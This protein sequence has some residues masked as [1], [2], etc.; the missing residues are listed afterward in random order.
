MLLSPRHI[1]TSALAALLVAAFLVFFG[2]SSLA[3][4]RP[5]NSGESNSPPVAVDDSYTTHGH[6]LLTPIEN[7]SDPDNDVINI[8]T[9]TQPQHGALE[10]YSSTVLHYWPASGYV[11]SDC[12]TYTIRDSSGNF[13]SA[14]INITIVNQAPV[15]V[16]D[17]YTVHGQLMISPKD[18]DYD[19]EGDGV[20]FQAIG[21]QPQHGTLTAYNYTGGYTYH[22]TYGYVGSDSFTYTI[23][24]GLGLTAT[25]TVNI[26][27]VNEGPVA[28]DDSYA[29][30]GQRV[31]ALRDNDYDPEG[32]GV[33]FQ[34]I[35]TQPQHGTLAVV[36]YTGTFTYMAAYGYIGPDS[37]TY[38]IQDGLGAT[39][40]G[41]V[42]IDVINQS[43]VPI[44]DVF[45]WRW[46]LTMYPTQNDFDPD[47]GDGI[48]IRD[49]WLN[50]QFGS[51]NGYPG[52][53]YTYVPSSN[54][55]G[56]DIFGYTLVDSYG[57]VA[58]G[59]ALIFAP[60]DSIN[61]GK[62][63][64]KGVGAP[65]DVTN[66]NMYLSQSDY[67]LPGAG[68]GLGV[69]RSYNSK[70]QAI[71]LFGR[72]WSTDYDNNIVADNSYLVHFR[73]GD[74]RVIYFFRP[75]ST[76]AFTP[77]L[78]DFHGQVTQGANG[79]T[80]SFQ[81]GSVQQFDA[82]GKLISLTDSNGNTTS[83]TYGAGGF[84][85]TVT[86]PVGRSL[87]VTTNGNGRATSIADTTGTIATYTYGGGNELLS[88]TYADNSGFHF[89]YDG[90][91]RLLTVTDALNNIVESHAYDSQGRATTSERQGGVEHY[92]L[93]YVSSTET[94]VT[95]ALSHVTKYTFDT[96]KG[97]NLLTRVEGVCGCGGGGGSQVQTW[98]YD[99]KLNL[100]SKTD[101]L[102]HITSFTYDANGNRLT[103]TDATGTVTYTYNGFGE[104]LT[105]TDQLNGVAMMTYD[106]HA[107]L[108]TLK[109]PLNNTTTFT[110][111]TRGQLLTSTDA[112]GKVTTFS[113]DTN[114]N[115]SENE[116]ANGNVTSFTHDD[117]GRLT[118]VHDALSHVTQYGY[119]VAG[120]LNRIT[121][122]DLS[123]AA[124][125]YDL[126]GRRTVITDERGNSTN[127]AYD[128]A[129]RLTSVTDAANHATTYGYDAMSK[130]TSVTDALSRVTNYD[131][132][133][134][135]RLIK[136][137]YP[138]ATTG[139]TRLFESIAYDA[140]GNVT[141][142]TDT[143]G[144]VTSYAYDNANR[145]ISTT[146]PA[147]KTTSYQYDALS[148]VTS[149][150]DALN[151]QYQ[152]GYDA[153]S[154]Q[155]Q[156]T[157]GGVSMTYVYDAVGNRSQRTDYNGVVTNYAYDDLNRLTTITYPD[158]TTVNYT[159]DEISRLAT[160]TN[161]NGTVTVGYDNR[162]RTANV[163]GPFGQTVSYG[164]DVDGNR[165]SL[166]IGGSTYA[167]YAYD[168]LNRLSSI[169]DS[170]SLAVNYSYDVTN[171]LTS[172]ILP[173]GV[174][175]SYEYDGLNRLTRLRNTTTSATLTD[176]QYT[177]DTANRISQLTDLGGTHAYGYDS[178][179]RVTTATYP[180][181]A[182]ESYTYDGV[183]NRTASH[184]SASYTYQPFNR[185]TSAGGATYTYDNNGNLLSKVSA[186]D[187]TQYAWDYENR[188]TQVTLPN[189]TVVNY[190]YDALGRRIQRTT[191]TGAD[192]RYVYDGQ[193]VI[194]DL[195]SSSAVVTSYLNG[196]GLDNHL[197]QTSSSTGSS[198]FLSDH[199][200]STVGLADSNGNL[201]ESITYD[202]FGNHAASTNT[203]YTYTGRERDS[204]TGLMYY[205]ARFYD[206]Q[207]G[208]FIGEDPI[209]L[210]GGINPYAYV[211][212][213]PHSLIDP[214]GLEQQ[215]PEN[216]IERLRNPLPPD[217]W[218]INAW[219]A[220]Q[221]DL[222][223]PGGY[224]LRKIAGW[225]WDVGNPCLSTGERIWAG[226]K[227]VG[228]TA[229]AAGSGPLIGKGI[230][231]LGDLL[232][233]G[234]GAGV[235]TAASALGDAGSLGESG[236]AEAAA[237]EGSAGLIDPSK[238]RFTQDSIRSTFRSGQSIDEVAR[239]LRGPNG[240]EI[241]QDFE[242]IRL[243]EN[244]GLLWTL[245]NR[246]LAAFGAGGRDVPFRMATQAEI[247]SE[248]G[249]KFTTTA[250]QGWG[251]FV[252]V[253]APVGPGR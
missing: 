186:T 126:A 156:V 112:R 214:L 234:G 49:L 129:Y 82:N 30:H 172:R 12:F 195:N 28:V 228:V 244:D 243:V 88:V 24:D 215:G 92:S 202:S 142:R 73:Q 208:R 245:D 72:G 36:N 59:I 110:Y 116:D 226:G 211:G 201:T 15:A 168:A 32:D 69:A 46:G 120:R 225:S 31:I 119:D 152:F 153:A 16:T 111:N 167:T 182:A 139:A 4:K 83:L 71:G 165:T 54:F 217:H 242:P 70:S 162:G 197:R 61:L 107:N 193:N 233:S 246:R 62:P 140:V 159:Y 178:V 224:L 212:N 79:F 122:P 252:T 76:G 20:D 177:Y 94:D 238:V 248:W 221:V 106:A 96:T 21:T 196:P 232:G 160:A 60:G 150:T 180:G 136:I 185:V 174:T 115:V 204:D 103:E 127:Y 218:I 75:G 63:G 39:A 227:I 109:D 147:N 130:L 91:Y 85:A 249:V 171:K 22:A 23:K 175:T 164:Y 58:P 158:T 205:R 68:P 144:R 241:A 67:Y 121:H 87:N 84:L 98:T 3:G 189:G 230:G 6:R 57:A 7:D 74:G 251:R 131:Y 42:C 200:G 114:G 14:T 117:R 209:G 29:V 137:T 145:R 11:G 93:N 154:R 151:Q 81:S 1:Y 222:I 17:S 148:R 18:N 97:R 35:A 183:G 187:T 181:A 213:N 52:G 191:S 184:L 53:Y 188:L 99:D 108:L 102:G 86:D 40:T 207:L 77:V 25:G 64:C 66:G 235:E 10:W 13:A 169:T 240:A 78:G 104:I 239:S 138:P 26:T 135:N 48:S 43:P 56:F 146:D 95:D 141:S 105:R 199:L 179:D 47:P 123:F 190:N 2:S 176:G 220:T 9:F 237:S 134:F 100:T 37:F 51:L 113:Y 5:R 216:Y 118:E 149:V 247:S 206:P 8:Y 133:D 163:T 192:E 198:Y 128:A 124:F 125:A 90:S 27:V 132:D 210:N 45:H 80:L 203:R 253:R 231:L 170:A 33:I 65:V 50:P 229:L 143:A 19:P 55:P 250:T 89:S 223:P 219:I 34:A 166:A 155:T 38:T 173:N 161:A 44:P 236:A 41:V 157:R 194:Q 101:A